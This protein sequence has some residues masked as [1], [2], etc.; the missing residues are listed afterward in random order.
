MERAV[1]QGVEISRG[2]AGVTVP[3][4]PDR[5][6]GAARLF[7]AVGS[8]GVSV[9]AI[10]QHPVAAGTAE[11]A[12]TV[13][14][15]GVVAV[16]V[17]LRAAGYA[18]VTAPV[19]EVALLGVAMRTDSAIPAIFSEALAMA[20]VPLTLVSL[21]NHRLSA[22]CQERD[23]GAAVRSLCEAFEV[24]DT[25]AAANKHELSGQ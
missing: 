1:V 2:S 4:V 23:A 16:V 25:R 19:A 17:A 7:R 10:A 3:A 18:P 13:P 8:A 12:F 14:R 21:E 22:F 20:G 15:T 6:G 11:V 9:G 24:P 5:P